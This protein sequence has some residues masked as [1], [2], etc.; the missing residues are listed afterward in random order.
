MLKKFY[1]KSALP[2]ETMGIAFMLALVGGYLDAYT[3]ILRGGVFANAQT[4]N[5]VLMG[6]SVVQNGISSVWVHAVPV[7]AFFFGVLLTSFMKYK[8]SHSQM[9][10]WEH[11]VFPVEIVL[12]F[13]VGLYP[14]TAPNG[15]VNV[16]ITFVCSLQVQSFRVVHDMPYASTM[17]T[18]NLRSAADNLFRF[19]SER[20]K[21]YL[22]N[23]I[24]YI[25]IIALFILGACAGTVFSG[26]FKEKSV[27]VCCIILAVSFLFVVVSNRR[28]KNK[29]E[30]L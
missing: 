12:L 19:F 10:T 28:I 3:F 18:G 1:K 5:I 7:L 22:Y 29:D 26:I 15:V 20:S 6:I 30:K 8:C 27:W 9:L 23:F 2:H 14:C 11:I 25:S 4:G 16:I 17:C 13:L 24:S 21:K